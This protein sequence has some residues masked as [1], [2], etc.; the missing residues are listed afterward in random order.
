MK[1]S[2]ADSDHGSNYNLLA[3]PY[4]SAINANKFLDKNVNIDGSLYIWEAKTQPATVG[5]GYYGQSDFITYT[6]AGATVPSGFS[7]VF[8]G[9]I[10]SA[11]GFMVRALTS[12]DVTFNN[13]MRLSGSA[14]NNSFFRSSTVNT[15]AEPVVDRFKLNL[16]S[17]TDHFNQVL[18]AYIPGLSMGYDRGYDASRNSTS[19]SQIFTIMGETNQRLAIDARPAFVD[20]D[21]VPLGFTSTSPISSTNFQISIVEKEVVFQNDNVDVFIHDKL[22]NVYHNFDNGVFNFT[23]SQSELLNRFDVVYQSST[24]D[25]PDFDDQSVMVS[26]SESNLLLSSKELINTAFI[27]DVTGRLIN[28]IDVNDFVYSGNFNHAQGVYIVR[29]ELSNG[30]FISNKVINK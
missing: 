27:F 26:L 10:A 14:D 8:N 1:S 7:G 30:Q 28:K 5:T 9:K 2:N 17:S 23:A 25:N 24:L 20:T 21:I 13:C 15:S 6:K 19:G 18:I 12:G 4:P 11:Q 29:V 3:N 22:N 16:T